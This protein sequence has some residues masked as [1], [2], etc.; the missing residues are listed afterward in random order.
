M[1]GLGHNAA[2]LDQT[3]FYAL[4][5]YQGTAFRWSETAA[6]VRLRANAVR[7]SIR[8]KCVP[9]RKLSETDLRFYLDAKRIPDDA[10]LTDVDDFEIRID[11]PQSGTGQLGWICRPF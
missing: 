7:Q 11:L 9:V 8:I 3:G 2:A 1:T 10:I 6:A 5:K 4:E